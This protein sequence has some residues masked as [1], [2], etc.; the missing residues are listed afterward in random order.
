[1][2]CGPI[3]WPTIAEYR[4]PDDKKRIARLDLDSKQQWWAAQDARSM[5][6]LAETEEFKRF[7]FFHYLVPLRAKRLLYRLKFW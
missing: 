1:M 4:W 5:I 2:N 3:H 6:F 7:W